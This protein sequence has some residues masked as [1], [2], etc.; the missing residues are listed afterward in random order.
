M[1]PNNDEVIILPEYFDYAG[2]RYFVK[3]S[4]KSGRLQYNVVAD[5]KPEEELARIV[6][7]GIEHG[8]F[9]GSSSASENPDGTVLRSEFIFE[10]WRQIGDSVEVEMPEHTSELVGE[11]AY[12]RSAVAWMLHKTGDS[13]EGLYNFRDLEG[14][15]TWLEVGYLLWV[16]GIRGTTPWSKINTSGMRTSVV[17]VRSEDG[18]EALDTRL[19]S[20][21][22]TSWMKPYLSQ[23]ATGKK[24]VPFPAY[25]AFRSMVD[26]FGIHPESDDKPL[27]V[28]GQLQIIKGID[29]S[30]GNWCIAEVSRKDMVKA[31]DKVSK[32][33][34]TNTAVQEP[35]VPK[36]NAKS[37]E[38]L[39]RALRQFK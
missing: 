19:S 1:K 29:I 38:A 5:I 18:R 39:D 12:Y 4:D 11:S 28:N 25:C 32:L 37:I 9:R 10:L 33:S 15:I 14:P 34:K 35:S 30:K 21:K 27:M 3:G 6:A 2:K 20:Y 7:E 31:L 17:S 36:R 23:I 8:V 16:L 24:Y 22:Q 26:E 13:L